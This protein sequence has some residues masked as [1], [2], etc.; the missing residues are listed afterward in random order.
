MRVLHRVPPRLQER[1]K[2]AY[3]PSVVSLGPYHHGQPQFREFEE[4][5]NKLVNIMLKADHRRRLFRANILARI[6]DIRHFY[7]GLSRDEYDEEALAEMMLG[8]VFYF[9]ET[10][11]G[12]GGSLTDMF[13]SRRLGMFQAGLMAVDVVFKLENQIPWWLIKSLIKLAYDGD[14]KEAGEALMLRFLNSQSFGDFRVLKQLPWNPVRDE[15]FPLHLLE[16][17]HIALLVHPEDPKINNPCETRTRT[18]TTTTFKCCKWWRRKSYAADRERTFR[19]VTE[20]K[21]KGIYFKPSSNFLHDIRF[22]S[23][24]FFGVLHLPVLLVSEGVGTA[25]SNMVALELSPVTPC[26][27]TTVTSYLVLMKSMIENSKD[28]KALQEKGIIVSFVGESEEIVRMFKEIDFD[29]IETIPVFDEIKMRINNHCK[30][31]AKTWIAQLINTYFH[32]PWTAIALLAAVFLL[33][34]TCLQTYYTLNPR[35]T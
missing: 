1:N 23:Y 34:L 14:K 15:Y 7:G 9:V 29:G 21:A 18:T 32:S 17:I 28:V 33:C 16:V 10:T 5:K 2:K 25:L 11:A 22:D 35:N 8:V 12:Y 26:T 4:L 27:D 6:R 20:L 13:Q 24:H 19:S 30:S 3:D 31:K